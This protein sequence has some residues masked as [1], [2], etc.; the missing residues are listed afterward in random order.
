[1]LA[2]KKDTMQQAT[3]A[4]LIPGQCRSAL[5]NLNGGAAR[6]AVPFV[7]PNFQYSPAIQACGKPCGR[8]G[9]CY[10]LGGP[11][12]PCGKPLVYQFG[13]CQERSG[14]AASGPLCGQLADS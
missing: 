6:W 7:G 4:V 13:M 5:P 3:D 2:R 10:Q 8:S 1:L 14:N 11:N 12:M 9:Y